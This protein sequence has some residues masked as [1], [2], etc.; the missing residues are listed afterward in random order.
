MRRRQ[1]MFL[2]VPYADVDLPL[3]AEVVG[4]EVPLRKEPEGGRGK[5]GG[6]DNSGNSGR[7]AG[8][9]FGPITIG[10]VKR[11]AVAFG[12]DAHNNDRAD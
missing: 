12:G 8:N 4:E 6:G 7:G 3:I 9:T 2:R 10:D 11:S 5:G 1:A